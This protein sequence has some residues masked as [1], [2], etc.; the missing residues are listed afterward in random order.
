MVVVVVA[1]MVMAAC[2]GW[3]WLTGGCYGGEGGES[4][5]YVVPTGR[6]IAIVSIKVHTGSDHNL[7][8][9]V[10]HGNSRKQTGRDPRGNIM[11]L[12]PIT[13]EEQI[14]V[15]RET[16]A[17]TIL[18]QSLPED[19]MADFHHLDDAKDI[20]LA[21]KARFGGNEESKKMRKS[22]LKQEFADFKIS[23]SEGLHKGY[24]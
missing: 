11:I 5:G 12:P 14:A 13:M 9:I 16:K 6:V 23:E 19:H 8:N 20:W 15:Q 2:E 21:V 1:V 17:R 10:L 7:W 18:L 22:M 4:E 3:W 24:D